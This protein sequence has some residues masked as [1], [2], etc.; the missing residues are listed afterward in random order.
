MVP[1]GGV[2]PP[3][4]SEPDLKPGASSIS[5]GGHICHNHGAQ[6]WIRTSGSHKGSQIYSLVPLA[7]QPSAHNLKMVRATRVELARLSAHDP[8]SW[9][10]PNSATLARGENFMVRAER[11]ELSCRETLAPEASVSA[12]STTLA[13]AKFEIRNSGRIERNRTSTTLRPP[14]PQ[15]GASTN[16]ATIRH[17]KKHNKLKTVQRNKLT[18]PRTYIKC[19]QKCSTISLYRHSTINLWRPRPGSNR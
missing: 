19:L 11:L 16:S 4:L 2:E 8:K 17:A 6:S 5:P 9:A 15:A 18:E 7:T 13:H 10:S 3:L 12:D 14:A 1:A